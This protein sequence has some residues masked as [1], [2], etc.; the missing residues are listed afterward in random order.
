MKQT[1]S[2]FL[3]ISILGIY[4]YTGYPTIPAYRDSGDLIS[5]AYTLGIAHPPGYPLY[6][7]CG[8]IFNTLIPYGNTG[9][10]TNLMS[11]IFSAITAL[12]LFV[13]I[14]RLSGTF[15]GIIISLTFAFSNAV[16]SLSH[17]SEMYTLLSFFIILFFICISL[18]IPVKVKTYLFSLVFAL[19]LSAQPSLLLLLPGFMLWF[20]YQLKN[21]GR[22]QLKFFLNIIM[23]IIIGIG[24]HLYLPVRS[25]AN[26]VISWGRL[27]TVEN[28][29]KLISRADYGGLKLHPGQSKF[30]WDMNS[31]S[32]QSI[33]FLKSAGTQFTIFGLL[34]GIAGFYFAH[35]QK[36]LSIILPG[37]FLTG[38]GF[39][40]LSNLPI[41]EKTTLPILEPHLLLPGT[42]FVLLIG[43][44]VHQI[45]K[46]GIIKHIKYLLI[47]IPCW[48]LLT[49]SADKNHREHFFAYDYGKNLLK[50]IPVKSILYDT[51]DPTTFIFT[52][53]QTCENKRSDI[54]LLTYFRTKW[55][56]EKFLKNH[57]ELLPGIIK[58]PGSAS[59]FRDIIFKNNIDTRG[60]YTD[61]NT[62]CFSPY[63]PNPEGLLYRI[64]GQAN[65]A[66]KSML[67]FDNFYIYRGDFNTKLYS[68]FFTQRILYYY[69]SSHNNLGLEYVKQ[70]KF[71]DAELE[72]KKALMID[73]EL[74]ESINNLGTLA[75][76]RGNYLLAVTYFQQASAVKPEDMNIVFNIG[77]TYKMMKNYDM[78]VETLNKAGNYP[79]ALNELGLILISKGEID[80]AVSIYLGLISRSPDYSYP[81]Y[82]LALAYQKKGDTLQAKQYYSKYMA[83]VTGPAEKSEVLSIINKLP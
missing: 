74:V 41:K 70:K 1:I 49:N 33:L 66:G 23:F 3:F 80:K 5:S 58:L 15:T 46:S 63:Y 54:A 36:T 16:W 67:L 64:T 11:M 24:I 32:E 56:A 69:S 17:V 71:A 34:L 20:Y 2:A 50:T 39:F 77:M 60:I 27:D 48:L 10:R 37:Y 8:K 73:P 14:S 22:L 47:L 45:P 31:I 9:Y 51:D 82:N 57:P 6:V 12:L 61:I 40:I 25:G 42:L 65:P 59:E 7:I 38:I 53:L 26:P 55:G 19:G 35:K 81:Y 18:Q 13:Y 76:S 75:F 29:Y 83:F 28:I 68:D 72:Y 52:Y 4:L 30:A 78:A 79:P 43:Y 44:T 62:K 21:T